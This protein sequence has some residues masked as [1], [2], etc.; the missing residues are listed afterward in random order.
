MGDNKNFVLFAVIAA[1]I[2]LGYQ[3]FYAGPKMEKLRQ[4]EEQIATEQAAQQ[5][6]EEP[7]APKEAAPLDDATNA[8]LNE[9]AALPDAGTVRIDTPE[10]RGS[11]SLRGATFDDLFLVKH[12]TELDENSANVRL[13]IPINQP[14]AY[15]VR[16][17]WSAAG[18]NPE[19]VPHA[20]SVWSADNDTLVPGKPVTLSWDNGEG[21]RF[22]MKIEV[23]DQFMFTVHQSVVNAT[24]GSLQIAP[25]G[26]ISRRGEPKTAGLYILHEGPLGVFNGKL[27]E[28]KYKD[29]EDDGNY[30]T[31][32]TGG[33]M[34]LTD[35]FWMTTL[36]PA[37][38]A[39]L[40]RTRFVRRATAA[41]TSYR[42]DAGQH[43][44]LLCW[45]QNCQ[46][47][48]R[49]SGKI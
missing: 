26:L 49:L 18:Q 39:E 19:F 36:I 20:N 46:H 48:R 7:I 34:G 13:L 35:K 25:Y 11:L 8:Q 45:R 33:W 28:K 31:S 21:V 15:Y 9:T 29:L 6:V 43:Q 47:H 44:P 16:F 30:E 37:Q 4:Y 2:L 10:L 23:D 3:Y 17:G 32:S 5:A 42:V 40:S 27:E 1:A 41:D 24:D 12:K 14:D 38:D 22:L